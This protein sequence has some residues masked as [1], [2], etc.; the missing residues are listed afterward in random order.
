VRRLVSFLVLL[1]ALPLKSAESTPLE[2]AHA[3]NDYE[4]A[5]PL[6]DAL[7]HGFCSVEADVYLIEG[8]LLVAHD[9]KDVKPGRTLTKLYLELLRQRVRENAGRVYRRG[10][11]V[12]L[13]VDVKS[14]AAATYAALHVELEKF[15]GM[16]TVFRQSETTPGAVTV[17]V[18]GNR[19][20]D[21]MKKQTV[22]YAA[23]DGRKEDLD[24]NP[25]GTFVPLVSENWRKVFTWDWQGK[26]PDA[27]RN[28][29]ERWVQRAHAQNRKVRFW[30]T[31]DR[32]DAWRILL[33]AGV[34]LVGTD[35][36]QGLEHF[37]RSITR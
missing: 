34:D 7:E 29:L 28:A 14:E 11:P 21:A 4:H 36:L 30:N 3:H 20:P 10:P 5:R 24:L 8:Q 12:V 22:R 35:D 18:S 2:R 13:L 27:D 19:A 25:P 31:P 17:I 1:T 37:L 9:R 16:L 15:A 26:I 23:L 32:E 6:L 33:D